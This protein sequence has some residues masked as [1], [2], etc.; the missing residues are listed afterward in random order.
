MILCHRE[1]SN[2]MEIDQEI[3]YTYSLKSPD[4]FKLRILGSTCGIVYSLH[5]P[6]ILILIVIL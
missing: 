6:V 2:T 4:N 3:V 1:G 5:M